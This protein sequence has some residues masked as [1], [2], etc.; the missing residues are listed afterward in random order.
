MQQLSFVKDGSLYTT[1]F[2]GSDYI[3]T[4]LISP[5]SNVVDS[6]KAAAS[7][8][9]QAEFKRISDDTLANVPVISDPVITESGE[10]FEVTGTAVIKGTAKNVKITLTENIIEGDEEDGSN[11]EDSSDSNVNI[12][13]GLTDVPDSVHTDSGESDSSKEDADSKDAVPVSETEKDDEDLKEIQQADSSRQYEKPETVGRGLTLN[14]PGGPKV[15]IKFGKRQDDFISTLG[16][17]MVIGRN[18]HSAGISFGTRNIKP[19]VEPEVQEAATR[20]KHRLTKRNDIE[21]NNIDEDDIPTMNYIEPEESLQEEW[22]KTCI[23]DPTKKWEAPNE[24][25]TYTIPDP[26]AE[27]KASPVERKALKESLRAN[28]PQEI[29]AVI[30]DIP[31]AILGALSEFTMHDVDTERLNEQK[32]IYCIDNRWH[33]CGKWFCIDVVNKSARYFFNSKLGVSVEIPIKIC[34]EWLE[35]VS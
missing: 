29:N 20:L 35:A 28:Y 32:D 9:F 21:V 19:V 12:D 1:I 10:G 25:D 4:F 15:G 3:K 34:K 2:G 17:S 23:V 7:G 27:E 18:S 26:I 11:V 8:G 14:S 16:P 13:S 6:S 5:G 31:H 30:G 22:K 33:K 24:T